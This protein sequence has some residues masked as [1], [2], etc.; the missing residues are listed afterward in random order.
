MIHR[1]LARARTNDKVE[2]INLRYKFSIPSSKHD[3]CILYFIVKCGDD[4]KLSVLFE[5]KKKCKRRRWWKKKNHLMRCHI[6]Q[7]IR[8]E[9]KTTLKVE[10]TH[11]VRRMVKYRTYYFIYLMCICV[12]VL[13]TA[14]SYSKKKVRKTRT[15]KRR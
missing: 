15:K 3:S 4:F 13:W 9:W 11:Q 8:S 14:R 1:L 7:T 5:Q 6:D 12:C 2:R 10:V